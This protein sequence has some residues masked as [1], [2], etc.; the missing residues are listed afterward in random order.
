MLRTLPACS[1]LF[2]LL[3]V[4]CS[5]PAADAG[6]SSTNITAKSPTTDRDRTDSSTEDDPAGAHDRS[7]STTSVDGLTEL[8]KHKA[9]MLTSIWENSTTIL[10]YG[11]CENIA[12]GRGFTSGRAGF[13]SGTGDAVL[14]V[15]CLAERVGSANRLARYLPALTE[16]ETAFED[17]GDDQADTSTLERVGSYCKDWSATAD[18]AAFREC[19]DAVVAQLYFDPA[20]AEAKKWGLTTALT[21]AELYDA[22]INHG[23]DGMKDL[24]VQ[25]NHDLGTTSAPSGPLSTNAES[26]WLHAFLLR[27]VKMLSADSTWRD[28]VDRVAVYE[29]LRVAGD[30]ELA[31][32]ITTD[33]KAKALFPGVSGL[34]DSGYPVCTISPTGVVG[35]D[36]DCTNEKPE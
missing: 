35:G 33:A 26:K 7:P 5:A 1:S 18:D 28:A 27:R 24:V 23:A 29:K 6:S 8:Q 10:Q 25:T 22:A 17:S 31:S 9:E 4:A 36:P 19:Q 20:I 12:D 34:I 2:L 32:A 21:K 14:V 3:V 13:C 30:F 16:L 11:Y 15:R